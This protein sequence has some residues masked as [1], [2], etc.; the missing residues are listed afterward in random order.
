MLVMVQPP[1]DMVEGE[2]SAED[3]RPVEAPVTAWVPPPA[4]WAMDCSNET[5]ELDA[6]AHVSDSLISGET[7]TITVNGEDAATFA[8]P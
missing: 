1:P 7:Y 5:L 4:P 6:I 8:V 2:W 3:G